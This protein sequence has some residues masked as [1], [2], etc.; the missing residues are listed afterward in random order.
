[1]ASRK[2][3]WAGSGSGTGASTRGP[4]VNVDGPARHLP[5]DKL[6]PARQAGDSYS[7]EIKALSSHQPLAG[8]LPIT[9]WRG[10]R[11][12]RARVL[13]HEASSG[14]K[15]SHRGIHSRPGHRPLAGRR[16]QDPERP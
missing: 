15:D 4:K 16:L 13:W 7:Y 8:G 5:S 12:H 9:V 3:T 6:S 2:C 14:L 1:A 11:L 10:F